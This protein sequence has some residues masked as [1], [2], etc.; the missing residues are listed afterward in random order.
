MLTSLTYY[1]YVSTEI[2][3]E[4]HGSGDV[5]YL[6]RIE[7]KKSYETREKG[8]KLRCLQTN[9]FCIIRQPKC[10]ILSAYY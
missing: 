10:I 3:L 9:G 8:R 2:E 1:E 5:L 6:T 4:W 7:T